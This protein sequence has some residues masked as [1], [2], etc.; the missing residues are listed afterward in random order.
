MPFKIFDGSS[1]LPSKKIKVQTQSGLQDYK[2]AFIFNGTSWV[3]VIEIPKKLTDP[4]LSYSKGGI[5]NGVGQNIVSTSMT[6]T[7]IK[8]L[9]LLS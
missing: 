3:E 9:L 6:L 2:K 1:W 4:E 5:I 7:Q 8:N